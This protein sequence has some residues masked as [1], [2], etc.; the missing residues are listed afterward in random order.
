MNLTR[1][2]TPV[3]TPLE[4]EL[5]QEIYSNRIHG[6]QTIHSET[7]LAQKYNIGRSSVRIALDNLTKE[8]LLRKV[9]GSGTFVVPENERP[10]LRRNI[11]SGELKNRQILFLSLS[12]AFSEETFNSKETH[13]PIFK[14]LSRV[15]QP[16]GY[17]ILFA[18]IGYDWQAPPCLLN[19]DIGGVIFDGIMSCEFWEK[20]MKHI[21]CV[22][23]NYINPDIEC[24]WVKLDDENRSH[25]AVSH[26][27]KL[28]HKRIGFLSD[29]C[30]EPIPKARLDAYLKAMSRFGLEV[31]KE[32]LMTWQRERI[33]GELK[34]EYKMPN[35]RKH[36]LPAFSIPESPTG[37][38]CFDNWRALCAMRALEK[39]GLRIPADVSIIG[40]YNDG[41]EY[42]NCTAF[43]DRIDDLCSEAAILLVSMI[44]AKTQI[45]DRTILL[46]PK[47]IVGGTTAPPSK[48]KI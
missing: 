27:V 38:I 19:N 25:Q 12:T 47:L 44:E 32:W 4:N 34:P 33:G 13:E 9:K 24:S 46:R 30:E 48:S 37:I 42:F 29:E 11:A 28:G 40:G 2:N 39:I 21:P 43:R 22:G 7:K 1:D 41:P 15:L 14:G 10:L 8:G 5:R 26:L 17:N 3:Y 23:L 20:Y 18:H 6:G 31:R 35:Y 16:R 45:P 36:I